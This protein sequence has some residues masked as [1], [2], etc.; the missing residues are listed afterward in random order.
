M[1][2]IFADDAHLNILEESKEEEAD[3]AARAVSEGFLATKDHFFHR[4]AQNIEWLTFVRQKVGPDIDL[5]HDPVGVYTFEEAVKVGRA[6]EELDYRWLEEPLPERQH[7]KLRQIC[8]TL[9]IPILATEMMM[10]DVDMCAQWL[11]S[12]ATDLI[13]ANARHGTTMAMK[14]ALLAELHGMNIEFNAAG[15]LFG[16]VHAHILCAVHNT[17]YYE[18]L[19]GG[20]QDEYG[21]EIG[22]TNPAVPEK[23]YIRPPDGPGW[24]AQWDW[25]QSKTV[26]VF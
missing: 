3:D 10:Y 5:M 12:G 2:P 14:L 16:L 1:C 11:I 21:K 9:D 7:N 13:R 17:S 6:L 25:K 22:M 8:G 15:G 18:Y 4:A 24:G 26:E 19:A 23:G 20:M